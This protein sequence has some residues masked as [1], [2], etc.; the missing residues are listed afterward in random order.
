MTPPP[1]SEY[2]PLS[3]ADLEVHPVERSETIPSAWYTD[4]GF[5][6]LDRDAVFAGT[7]QGVGHGQ[8]VDRPGAYFLASIADNPIIVLA[9]GAG[10]PRAFYN[11]CR[12]RGGPLATEPAG[13]VK[14]LS[15]KYHGWTY[16]LDGTLRGVPRFDRTELFDKGDYGL[17]PLAVRQWRGFLFAHLGDPLAT[18]LEELLG[19]ISDRIG[20]IPIEEM[21]L[22][23][24]VDYQV[25]ANWKV[26]VDNFLEGYH[27]PHVHPELNRALDYSSYRTE[28]AAWHSLQY[29]P[30]KADNVYTGGGGE[31]YYYWIYP[32]LMLNFLPHRIQANLVVPEGPGRCRV[33]FW[34]YYLDP[35]APGRDRQIADDLAYSDLVQAE[36]RDICERVQ[37]GLGSRAYDRGRFSVDME[38]GVH[39][40][41]QLL[42]ASYRRWQHRRSLDQRSA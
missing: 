7:W 42:K 38:S 25:G 13:C 15:C 1:D 29:S 16:W 26:Y 41:Q 35:A 11:V 27:I 18:P 34:Y 21:R 4:P 14:A 30:L 2:P 22:V 8:M 5:H 33:I 24:R 6:A 17:V 12:H 31:A 37:I 32:N 10:Q 19:G 36:D 20:P 40:F 3:E 28:L 23:H 39:H 9:D